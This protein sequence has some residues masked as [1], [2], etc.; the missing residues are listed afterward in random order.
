MSDIVNQAVAIL[1]EKLSAADF[2][3]TAKFDIQGEGAIMMDSTGARA[4][5]EEAD[6]T[7]SADA[8]TFQSIL[9][10]DTNPTAAFMSGKLA[11]DGDMGMAMKLASV[12]A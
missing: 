12:L 6:V 4:G 9:E 8:D 5:D 1:N 2:D 11:V 3:G 7:L 10:G